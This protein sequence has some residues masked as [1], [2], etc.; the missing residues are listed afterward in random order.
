MSGGDGIGP[1]GRGLGTGRGRERR[2]VGIRGEG[3][4]IGR[5]GCIG[6]RTTRCSQSRHFSIPAPVQ[7]RDNYEG[8]T[9]KSTLKVIIGEEECIG[10]AACIPVCPEEAISMED[11]IHIDE[12]KCTGCGI[13]IPTCPVGAIKL[14][15]VQ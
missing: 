8:E 11:K 7:E 3:M 5:G 12:A 14:G 9:H 1:R 15:Q 2:R 10:C 13:C 4:S 6:R